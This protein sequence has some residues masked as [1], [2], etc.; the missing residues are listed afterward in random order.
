MEVLVD[1]SVWIDY[2]RAGNK[3]AELDDLIDE[4][5]IVTNDLIL[6]ELI[7]FLKLKR[8]AEVVK[9]LSEIKRIP[10]QIDWDDI[11]ESQ[12]KCLKSGSNGIGIPDL[13]IAQ[14]AKENHCEVF[15]LDKHFQVL[16]QIIKVKL[17]RAEG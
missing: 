7:P 8:Q 15:S 9:L 4:N 17:Y 11:I 6:T 16:N 12:L 5:V 1:T 2:F 3:S 14:N 13:I 10:L